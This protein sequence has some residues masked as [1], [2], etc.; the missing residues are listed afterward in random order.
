MSTKGIHFNY[1]YVSLDHIV[2]YLENAYFITKLVELG[3][4]VVTVRTLWPSIKGLFYRDLY[5]EVEL[6]YLSVRVRK[7]DIFL[8]FKYDLS[9]RLS[10]YTMQD[11]HCTVFF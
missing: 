6:W 11:V 9:P 2:S 5:S 7:S 1:V 10:T 8:T 4:T 3:V